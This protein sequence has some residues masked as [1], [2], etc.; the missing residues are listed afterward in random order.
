MDRTEDCA[1]PKRELSVSTRTS[2]AWHHAIIRTGRPLI[3]LY[4]AMIARLVRTIQVVV[5]LCG[6]SRALVLENLALR[7]RL[8]MYQ[9]ELAEACDPA[10]DR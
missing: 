9:P 6:G 1:S 4:W 2:G 7:Q 8:G 5:L 10:D 3:R